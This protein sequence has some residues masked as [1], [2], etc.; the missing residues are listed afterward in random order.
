M[1]IDRVIRK[2]VESDDAGREHPDQDRLRLVSP[3]LADPVD[4]AA[5]AR[6]QA[7]HDGDGSGD[8]AGEGTDPPT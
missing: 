3:N 5:I 7:D 6:I 4:A 1:R 2:K 8:R